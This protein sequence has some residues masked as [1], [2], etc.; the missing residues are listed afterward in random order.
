MS[1]H[2]EK[3]PVNILKEAIQ[4][5]NVAIFP[6]YYSIFPDK[7][8]YFIDFID[9]G[10][11]QP[12]PKAREDAKDYED[13]Y[14]V[15]RKGLIAFWGYMTIIADRPSLDLFPGLKE[16]RSDLVSIFN[17]ETIGSVAFISLSGTEKKLERHDDETDNIYIQCVG[18]VTWRIYVGDSEEYTDHLLGPGDM[19]FVPM[20]ASHEVFPNSPRCAIAFV[21]DGDT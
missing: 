9:Y 2:T 15:F 20:G 5:K 7:W 14:G 10:S 11:Q 16:I 4:N 8:D 6:K 17:K 19:I 13:M 21:F 12:V 1:Q 18:S 3:N